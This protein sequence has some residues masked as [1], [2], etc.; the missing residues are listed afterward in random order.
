MNHVGHEIVAATANGKS[1]VVAYYSLDSRDHPEAF[2]SNRVV[3]GENDG[4]LRTVAVDEPLRGV[5]VDDPPVLDDGDPVTQ[6]FG[7]FHQMRGQKHCL[8]ALPDAPHQIP[9]GSPRLRVKSCG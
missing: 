5:N 2:F 1:S 9:D 8:A 3:S 6:P 7:L 4:S